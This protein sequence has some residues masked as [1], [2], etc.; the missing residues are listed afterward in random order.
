MRR[1]MMSSD[2]RHDEL[3]FAHAYRHKVFRDVT[4]LW[5]EPLFLIGFIQP[6][7]KLNEEGQPTCYFLSVD[8]Y[9]KQRASIMCLPSA[10]QHS[11]PPTQGLTPLTTDAPPDAAT[12]PPMATAPSHLDKLLG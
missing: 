11:G 3:N 12:T 2:G 10:P 1:G 6:S 4:Q 5:D 9:H 7:H 8:G